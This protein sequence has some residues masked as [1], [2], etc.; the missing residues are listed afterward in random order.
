MVKVRVREYTANFDSEDPKAPKDV[1]E[2]FRMMHKEVEI[3]R[4]PTD[5]KELWSGINSMQ[6]KLEEICNRFDMSFRCIKVHQK[7]INLRDVDWKFT[8]RKRKVE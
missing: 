7:E 2:L 4:N 1:T 3:Y 8:K 6:D 5:H